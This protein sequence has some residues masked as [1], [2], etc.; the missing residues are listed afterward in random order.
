DRDLVEEGELGGLLVQP[1]VT[2]LVD[3]YAAVLRTKRHQLDLARPGDREELLAALVE[4]HP[5]VAGGRVEG[6]NPRA[7]LVEGDPRGHA[8]AVGA[9]VQLGHRL[10]EIRE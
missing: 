7:A 6:R 1:V 5:L 2:N 8:L 4:L 10:D 9:D 3:A